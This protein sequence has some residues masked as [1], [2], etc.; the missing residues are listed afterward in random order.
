M[1]KK[2]NQKDNKAS[3]PEWAGRYPFEPDKK[4]PMVLSRQTAIPRIY[5]YAQHRIATYLHISTDRIS[6]AE[7]SVSPGEY[8]EPPD[9]HSGDEVYYM[10]EGTATV[11]NPETGQVYTV[12]QGDFFYI[13]KGT[14]HQTYNYTVKTITIICSFAPRMWPEDAE[15]AIEFKGT[16]VYYKG[17]PEKRQ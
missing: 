5:G 10:L 4:R 9:I 13:S 6:C 14:W 16:P 3:F 8:F 11:L 15:L 7:F 17:R 2:Q 1:S 12:E